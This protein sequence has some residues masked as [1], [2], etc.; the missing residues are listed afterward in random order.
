MLEQIIKQLKT[1]QSKEWSTPTGIYYR[2]Q[3]VKTAGKVVALFSGQGSQYVN[4]GRELVCHFPSMMAS[5]VSID[6][7]FHQAGQANLSNIVYPIPVFDDQK[8]SQQELDLRLTQYAQPAIG[9]FSVGL[10]NT[11]KQAGFKAD[12]AAGHSFGELT[13]LWA[14]GVVSDT[15]YMTLARSRGQGCLEGVGCFRH[16][17]L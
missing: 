17:G 5:Q 8:R 1:E 13:A 2:E 15:D 14:A 9:S 10:F 6:Q 11:F 7:Q 4:M 3:G 12:F 16:I